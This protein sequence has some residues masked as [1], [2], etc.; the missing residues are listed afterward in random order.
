MTGPLRSVTKYA[1]GSPDVD[2]EIYSQGALAAPIHMAITMERRENPIHRRES[3][4]HLFIW[5]FSSIDQAG[6]IGL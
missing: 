2:D 1:W 4:L 3:N 5:Y 6:R